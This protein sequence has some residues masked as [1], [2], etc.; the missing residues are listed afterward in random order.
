MKYLLI[1][2]LILFP[3]G[4]LGR[5]DLG[6]GVTLHL[7]DL[8]V[9]IVGGIG[10]I[11]ELRTG[12]KS[13]LF[14][15]VA[16]WAAAMAL[17]LLVNISRYTPFQ[18]A[19]AGMYAVRWLAYAGIYFAFRETKEKELIKKGLIAGV[20][21]VALAGIAQYLL[22]PDTTFLAAQNWDEHYF[23]LIS[24]FLDPG[25]T[26]IILTL[27]LFS[28]FNFKFKILNKFSI[29]QFSII[30]T[31]LL[32]TYSRASYL[33]YLVGFGIIAWY[34]KSLKIILV[35][36]IVLLIAIPLLPKSLGEG[37]KL[38]RENS[39]IARINNWKQAVMI[40]EKT[41]ILG[42]GFDAYRYVTNASTQSHAGA[43][44]DS[45][46][47]L[48][49]ATTGIVGLIAYLGVLRGMWIAGKKSL[50]FKASF[51]AVFV[52]SWFNNTLLYPWVMEWLFLLL[53]LDG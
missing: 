24:T 27:G 50:A 25:F 23:R 14:W 8:A 22:M 29:L 32:L 51:L 17:S 9:G 31:A 6:N 47:L 19:V 15:P 30:Y 33:A 43:G 36:T 42:R 18:L 46:I 21:I 12:K 53:V 5:F 28:I 37:T 2:L 11:R 52:H 16:I 40:W 13:A 3:L 48:V 39:A 35:A 44:A 45:S 1:L 38:G 41:P 7:N 26:G 4:Q 34:K 49:L 20:L 10:I